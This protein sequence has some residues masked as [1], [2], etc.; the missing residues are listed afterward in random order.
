MHI[1]RY[2]NVLSWLTFYLTYIWRKRRRNPLALLT[3]DWSHR[4]LPCSESEGLHAMWLTFAFLLPSRNIWRIYISRICSWKKN[5]VAGF[6]VCSVNSFA[7]PLHSL[8]EFKLMFELT[9]RVI[10]GPMTWLFCWFCRLVN[11]FLRLTFRIPI[12]TFILVVFTVKKKQRNFFEAW[13]SLIFFSFE[14]SMSLELFLISYLLTKY[15][16]Y[17]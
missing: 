7:R 3:D 13:V 6:A 1:S 16:H 9:V 2:L 11:F 17:V 5:H 15:G 4:R 14:G 8:D 10:S 12:T